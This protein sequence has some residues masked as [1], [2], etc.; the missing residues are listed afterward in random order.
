MANFY[1]GRER[2]ATWRPGRA[3][4]LVGSPIRV[5]R[6][7]SRVG[8]DGSGQAAAWT[9]NRADTGPRW[10]TGARILRVSPDYE[11]GL[12]CACTFP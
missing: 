6:H 9:R 10:G 7:P 3:E 12:S 4:A 2:A 11:S 1:G 8:G 5:A